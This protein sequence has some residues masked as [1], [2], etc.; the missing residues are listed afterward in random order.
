MRIVVYGGSGTTG[1][2][3]AREL[4]R[5]EQG[6]GRRV[7][8]VA[9]TAHALPEDRVRC[10]AAGMDGYVSKPVRRDELVAALLEH[11]PEPPRGS[12]PPGS[13]ADDDGPAAPPRV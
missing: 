5:R 11:L 12:A 6:T 2:L 10:L 8:V 7:P 13:S 9:M 1:R 3:I 4:R